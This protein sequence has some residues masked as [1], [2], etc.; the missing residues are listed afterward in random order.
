MNT[1]TQRITFQGMHENEVFA[2]HYYRHWV[3]FVWPLTKVLFWN[4]FIL[5]LLFVL[6][7]SV[8]DIPV[9]VSIVIFWLMSIF[10]LFANVHFLTDLYRRFLYVIVVTDK[11]VHRIR[12]TLLTMNDHRSIDI[13]SLQDVRKEQHGSIQN[14]LGYG[15]IVLEAQETKLR[16]HYVPSVDV[17]HRKLLHL[18]EVARQQVTA[19]QMQQLKQQSDMMQGQSGTVEKEIIDD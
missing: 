17:V 8:S 1:E 7:Y 3:K 12:K 2:F 18:R 13:W 15:D 16:L 5:L 14:V 19:G 4:G 11:K 9:A 6:S 10:M